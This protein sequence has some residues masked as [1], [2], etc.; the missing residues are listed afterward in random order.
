[1]LVLWPAKSENTFG[2]HYCLDWYRVYM[3]SSSDVE[4]VG[5]KLDQFKLVAA[6]GLLIASFVV[7][8]VLKAHGAWIQWLGLAACVAMAAGVF[9]Q[10]THG[11]GLMGYFRDTIRETKK[12][13]WPDRK[14]AT[15]MTFYVFGFVFVMSLFL[16]L[17]DKSIEWL[18]YDLILNWRK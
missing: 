18:F 16:W 7:F 13:V 4:V 5:D 6:I 2:G 11:R 8:Y 12:V 10:S 1:L 14:E 15:Q 17:T 9:F 3:A